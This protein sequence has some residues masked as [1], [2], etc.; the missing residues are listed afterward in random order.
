MSV[1]KCVFMSVYKYMYMSVYCMSVS[2]SVCVCVCVFRKKYE[3]VPMKNNVGENCICRDLCLDL[4]S[5]FYT[6]MSL[7]M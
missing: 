2:I 7:G 3:Y 1:Y 6:P 4:F 5:C